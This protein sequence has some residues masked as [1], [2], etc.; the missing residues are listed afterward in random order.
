MKPAPGRLCWLP[1]IAVCAIS[2]AQETIPPAIT[3]YAQYEHPYSA[4]SMEDMKQEMENIMVPLG[5]DFEWRSLENHSAYEVSAE[6]VVVTFKG[7]CRLENE[8]NPPKEEGGPLGWT[9]MSDGVVLPFS[10]VDCDKIRRFIGAETRP[11]KEVQRE[12]VYGRAVGR[13]L[14]HELYH[15]FTNTARHGSDG[16][17]KACYT[18]R[19]LVA[20][21]FEF[22]DQDAKALRNGKLKALLGAKRPPVMGL[23]TAGSRPPK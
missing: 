16:V 15:V 7:D 17:A 5:L 19:E 18:P 4:V 20:D 13:V 1:L 10:E 8:W 12:A 6:L 2:R 11:M 3:V 23:L 14:A 22:R 21:H 9:H